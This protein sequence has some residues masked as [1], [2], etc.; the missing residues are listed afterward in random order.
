[1]S[2]SFQGYSAHAIGKSATSDTD[3]SPVVGLGAAGPIVDL[4]GTTVRS[5]PPPTGEVALT[6]D[7]GPDPTWTPQV[8]AILTR[9][10][11]PATFFV[12]GSSA[13]AHPGLVKA[14][15]SAGDDVGSHTFTH[16]DLGQASGLRD[17]VEL[18]LTQ[19]ALAGAGGVSTALLRLPYSSVPSSVTFDE[20]RAAKDAARFGYL[21]VFATQ[22]PRDWSRPGVA[23][24][25]ANSE[26]PA[27]Q[28]GVVMLHD[29]GGDRSE[30]VAAL[31]RIIDEL[32]ARGD[33]F[34]TVS[35][36]AGLAH[37]AV[38]R[39][40]GAAV[41]AQ[42]LALLSVGRLSAWIVDLV[43][44]LTIPF[45]LL[46][47]GRAVLSVLLARRH[48]RRTRGRSEFPPLSD[49]ELP[50]VTVLVPAYNEEVGIARTVESL[51]ESGYPGL[52][53]IVIDDG[54][55]DDTTDVVE[56]LGLPGVRLLR[57]SNQGK[58]AAL[59]HGLAEASNRLVVMMDGDTV[60][61][62]DTIRHLV[63][64]FVRDESVG[65]VSGNTKVGNRRSLLGLWQHAEYVIGFNLDRRM[66]DS[67]HCIPTIPGAVGG[68][69]RD[70]VEAVGGISDDTL[71]ED[72]DITMTIQRRGWRVVY[73]P[74]AIAW[75]E[76]P[77]RLSALWRQRYR[78]GY[79][80]LQAMWKHK[81]A[82][83]EG[84]PLE[85]YGLPYLFAFQILL[86]TLSPVID[87]FAVYGALFLDTWT[88]IGIWAAYNLLQVLLGVYAFHL[89]RER[90]WPLW[91]LPLQQLVYRQ[92]VYLVVIQSLV[93][94]LTGARLRWHKL[95]RTGMDALPT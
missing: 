12:V 40:V 64:P 93:S 88:I 3:E 11:V 44:W 9:Y 1:V 39:P 55:T 4:S 7:D 78:W 46:S 62:R 5:V 20:Y 80:T 67:L 21:T 82:V 81:G 79:G 87:V 42:G 28:G 50:P 19:T 95:A 74:E 56:R 45:T 47:I 65:A 25:V 43:V 32:R 53:V 90:M 35:Q 6:F 49:D 27:G 71:A 57:Q 69:R 17:S 83:R 33:R 59:N 86:P 72:T 10:R 15:L 68:F 30:T 31:P 24:I 92:L 13:L 63:A 26:P 22:D 34:V 91:T 58:A 14:E 75:T 18:S 48:D 89:D 76:A 73:Q 54:S 66:W 51:I 60:F 41:R 77:T 37:G 23:W 61:Q 70:V 36:M 94:A 8:L 84:N 85:R 16:V 29:G 38:D 2:L 52:E